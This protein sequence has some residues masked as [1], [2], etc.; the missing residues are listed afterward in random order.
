MS[1]GRFVGVAG[2]A[3]KAGALAFT[4]AMVALLM[5]LLAAGP[6]N[7]IT[8]SVDRSDDPNLTTTP[9]ANNCSLRGAITRSNALS[10]D[11]TITFAIPSSD[12]NCKRDY[13]RLHDL[14]ELDAADDKR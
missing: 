2:V 12:G 7:A 14:P 9:T 1:S 13:G 11:D 3:S 6:A 4:T 8:F 10:T 5:V